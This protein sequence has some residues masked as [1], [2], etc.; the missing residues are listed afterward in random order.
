MS[1]AVHAIRLR[2]TAAEEGQERTPR[3]RLEIVALLKP[4]IQPLQ[5][6]RTLSKDA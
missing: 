2:G 1:Q 4:V 6:E 5:S 3:D